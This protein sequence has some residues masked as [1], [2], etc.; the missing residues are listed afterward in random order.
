MLLI[1]TECWALPDVAGD[2]L[3]NSSDCIE[4]FIIKS[5]ASL[6]SVVNAQ[7]MT[8]YPVVILTEKCKKL[9][10]EVG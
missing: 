9:Q 10:M 1:L 6:R 8:P 3:D 2:E 4:R 5:D 7:I